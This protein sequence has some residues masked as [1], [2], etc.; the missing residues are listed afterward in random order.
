MKRESYIDK[1][2]LK[3]NEYIE[4]IEQLGADARYYNNYEDYERLTLK[5]KS[6]EYWAKKGI[7][8]AKKLLRNAEY[9]RGLENG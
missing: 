7:T 8:S 6:I 9:E 5:L 3:L 4:N 2:K 1:Q